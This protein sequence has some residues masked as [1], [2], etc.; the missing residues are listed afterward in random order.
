M[1]NFL[2][3]VKE[4]KKQQKGPYRLDNFLTDVRSEGVKIERVKT[5]MYK[6]DPDFFKNH[7]KFKVKVGS[8]SAE[9]TIMVKDDKILLT[10]YSN[11]AFRQIILRFQE[12]LKGVPW[13]IYREFSDEAH[14]ECELRTDIGGKDPE[15]FRKLLENK[16]WFMQCVGD[17]N[18]LRC[19]WRI[20]KNATSDKLIQK[21]IQEV[22]DPKKG[23]SFVAAHNGSNR[24]YLPSYNVPQ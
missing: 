18:I 9:I 21:R 14:D 16:N 15:Y 17:E 24:L 8:H 12:M 3:H 22:H 10:E 7:G 6:E 1:E 20:G 23:W 5:R 11:P 2:E 13:I 19:E 4:I